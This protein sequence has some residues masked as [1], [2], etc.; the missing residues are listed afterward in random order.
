MENLTN[1]QL[2]LQSLQ[3]EGQNTEVASPRTVAY[4]E[5]ICSRCPNF[6]QKNNLCLE[7]PYVP[8]M[9]LTR[10]KDQKCPK[11]LW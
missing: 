7:T 5:S 1:E 2:V 8:L 6:D 4:R 3:E 10:I 9:T 11:E